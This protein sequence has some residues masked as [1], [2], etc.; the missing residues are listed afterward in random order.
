[1]S[2]NDFIERLSNEMFSDAIEVE[3]LAIAITLLV[4]GAE[5]EEPEHARYKARRQKEATPV[6]EPGAGAGDGPV[7]ARLGRLAPTRVMRAMRL[8]SVPVLSEMKD[9]ANM[10][11][12]QFMDAYLG[13]QG[14]N[15]AMEVRYHQTGTCILPPL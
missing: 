15:Q 4:A 2:G 9:T 10:I 6:R 1:M 14:E 7:S 8:L 3:I 11:Q 12:S 13:N 5:A